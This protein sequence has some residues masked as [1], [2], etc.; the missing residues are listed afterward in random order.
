M[1]KLIS[2]C[3]IVKFFLALQTTAAATSTA[4]STEKAS[5]VAAPLKAVGAIKA[6]GLLNDIKIL[7]SDEFEGRS[8]G[9][10]GESM[11][12]NYLTTQ[13]KEIGLAPGNP[14]GTYK[15]NV[16]LIGV[17]S[18]PTMEFHVGE[19]DLSLKFPDDFVAFSVSEDK[20]IH[21]KKSDIVFVG[22]GVVAPEYGWD[23][24][25]GVDLHGKTILMLIND[26]AIPDPHDST[27]L[28]PSMFK[29]DEMTYYGRWTYKY[30]MAAR[31]GAAGAIIIHET[32]PAA[33]PYEVVKNS[34]G[35]ENFQIQ[36]HGPNPNFP[37]VSAW[38]QL[39][40]AKELLQASGFDF[41]SLKKAAL[42]KDFK[43]VALRAQADITVKN[44][45]KKIES[46]NVIASLEG[47][48]PIL[49]KEYIIY[50]AHWDHFGID[51]SLPGPKTNQIF[52]GASD[53]ASGVATLLELAK[54]Y[55]ALPKTQAPKRTILFMATTAEER[56][57]LGA[58]YY[59]R[60]P[61]YPLKKTLVNINM[62][63]ANLW[64]RTKDVEITGFGKSTTDD[65]VAQVAA[66]QGRVALPE[67]RPEL[68]GFFRADQFEFAKE[69]I[70][71]LYAKGGSRF[72]GKPENYAREKVDEYIAHDYHKVTDIVRPDWDLSGAV[73]DAQLLF[74]IGYQ[75]AQTH[76]PPQWKKGAEFAAKRELT[77]P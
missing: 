23:D 70:P 63:G 12:V 56:G 38:I 60:N 21:I 7:A 33:Y 2:F 35:R 54:A 57:L 25:K 16:P 3:V 66:G 20:E 9:T 74:L 65:I 64:G 44:T 32:K 28:D 19:K 15:Q 76:S 48:D 55:K 75:L 11:T 67:A 40:R 61:L 49:K 77:N 51:E 71:V 72:I 47:R 42:K 69:G 43:P 73:E 10:N 41:D 17:V 22:Y 45:S 31:L 46:Q 14:N 29:G 52:H 34:W 8:P 37:R 58:Q 36:S 18:K 30:E 59:V 1:K 50:T 27:K 62:D 39:D 6:E 68:G 13:F 5:S 4:I 53:N 24:Y 26:P